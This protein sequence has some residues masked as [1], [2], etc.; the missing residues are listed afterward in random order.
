MRY[1]KLSEVR[2]SQ[3]VLFEMEERGN[4]GGNVLPRRDDE[5]DTNGR[6]LDP[7]LE[8]RLV[9]VGEGHVGEA[10]RGDV[11]HVR[12]ALER[13]ADLTWALRDWPGAKYCILSTA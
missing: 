10:R 4:E 2:T 6:A 7:A 3:R 11:E 13:A 8:A 9:G 1:G 12:R 5:D